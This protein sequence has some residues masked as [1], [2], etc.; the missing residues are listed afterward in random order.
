[1]GQLSQFRHQALDICKEDYAEGGTFLCPNSEPGSKPGNLP[2]FLILSVSMKWQQ[3]NYAAS[4]I[5]EAVSFATL[6]KVKGD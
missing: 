1:M 4:C 6:G 2:V 5:S 3:T